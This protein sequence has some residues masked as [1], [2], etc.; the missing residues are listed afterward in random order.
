MM[1]RLTYSAHHQNNPVIQID[2][3]ANS[4]GVYILKIYTDDSVFVEKVI[5][6]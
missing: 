4:S 6:Q 5:K 1:G 3:G 2:M